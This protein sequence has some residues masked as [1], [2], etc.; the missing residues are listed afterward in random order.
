[1]ISVRNER[2]PTGDEVRAYVPT[3][4]TTIVATTTWV[5]CIIIVLLARGGQ[6]EKVSERR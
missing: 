6:K 1:L 2:T 5:G 4:T 3:A